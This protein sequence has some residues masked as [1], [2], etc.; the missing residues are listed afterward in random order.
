MLCSFWILEFKIVYY[1]EYVNKGLL[2]RFEII[3]FEKIKYSNSF[4]GDWVGGG[5]RGYKIHG[6]IKTALSFCSHL[7]LAKCLSLKRKVG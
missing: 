3:L 5:R 2:I 4:G 7:Q 1:D 6:L